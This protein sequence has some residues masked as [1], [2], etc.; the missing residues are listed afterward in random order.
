MIVKASPVI[1]PL[2][3]IKLSPSCYN[4]FTGIA[5]DD[6]D[7]MPPSKIQRKEA[8]LR[9]H[10]V[11]A[12][13]STWSCSTGLW[14]VPGSRQPEMPGSRWT[15][16]DM[17]DVAPG[18]W[19]ARNASKSQP[20][21][22]KATTLATQKAPVSLSARHSPTLLDALSIQRRIIEERV[23]LKD[24]G[25]L[26]GVVIAKTCSD[27]LTYFILFLSHWCFGQVTENHFTCFTRNRCNPQTSLI[28][29]RT[30]RMGKKIFQPCS[31]TKSQCPHQAPNPICP[32]PCWTQN[33]IET[34]HVWWIQSSHHAWGKK[35][36]R[37]RGLFFL[38]IWM[39]TD[40]IANIWLSS[41]NIFTLSAKHR[42][43][44]FMRLQLGELLS[45]FMSVGLHGL[46]TIVWVQMSAFW[47]DAEW[48]TPVA[49]LGPLLFVTLGSSFFV[50]R[51]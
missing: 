2:S 27:H 5:H 11:G 35:I 31:S 26:A 12:M 39:G 51:T 25:R 48:V 21:G 3:V 23:S 19:D 7:L 9:L 1:K 28:S 29:A 44:I 16:F 43:R 30:K 38:P 17:T 45:I 50:R 24:H 46:S 6:G 41:A 8:I 10:E 20:V 14:Q 22:M 34:H 18:G 47:K 13:S 42:P 32:M 37:V 36:R 4:A 40:E 49:P 15:E 33:S